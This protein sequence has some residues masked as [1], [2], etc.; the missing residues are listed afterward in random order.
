MIKP[1]VIARQEP[2]TAEGHGRARSRRSAI[3]GERDAPFRPRLSGFGGLSGGVKYDR[4][5]TADE[6]YD[7]AGYYWSTMTG[8]FGRALRLE[9]LKCSWRLMVARRCA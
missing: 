7:D 8:R 6:S 1:P 5:S 3:G 9:G 4:H 2:H